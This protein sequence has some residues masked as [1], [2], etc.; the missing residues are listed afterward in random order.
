[1]RKLRNIGFIVI[2]LIILGFILYWGFSFQIALVQSGYRIGDIEV[3]EHSFDTKDNEFKVIKT[4]SD[5]EKISLVIIKKNRIGIWSISQTRKDN[6]K[7]IV[8]IAWFGDGGAKRY[9]ESE[10]PIFYDESHFIY[11]GTNATKLIEFLPEQI[12]EDV[13][14]SVNQAGNVYCVHLV[15]RGKSDIIGNIDVEALL[16]KNDMISSW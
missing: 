12:P 15:S 3:L 14:V 5:K 1:M 6:N 2:A 11:Y 7:G 16:K 4:S 10:N 13:T 9:S 8:S